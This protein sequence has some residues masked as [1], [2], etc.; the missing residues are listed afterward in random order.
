METK[1]YKRSMYEE[2]WGAADFLEQGHCQ[3]QEER[4]ELGLDRVS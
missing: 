1:N 4:F 3:M 2:C